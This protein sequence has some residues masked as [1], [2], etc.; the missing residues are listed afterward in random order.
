MLRVVQ[1]REPASHVNAGQAAYAVESLRARFPFL[2]LQLRKLVAAVI[3]Q[4][5]V[6]SGVL[7]DFGL[8]GQVPLI[9]GRRTSVPVTVC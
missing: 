3:L 7:I 5:G 6:W 2:K 8:L 4:I 1:Q 9:T